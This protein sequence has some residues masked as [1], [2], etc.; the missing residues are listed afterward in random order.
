M[1]LRRTVTVIIFALIALL[2]YNSFKFYEVKSFKDMLTNEEALISINEIFQI[3]SS[4]FVISGV[5]IA[6]WQYVSTSRSEITKYKSERVQKAIELSGYYKDKILCNMSFLLKVYQ[7]TGI[8]EVIK[9]VKASKFHDFDEVELKE[10]YSEKQIEEIARI[11]HSQD[12]IKSVMETGELFD[13]TKGLTERRVSKSGDNTIVETVVNTPKLHHSFMD[14][15]VMSTL[16]NLEYFAMHFTHK[17]A[18]ESVVYQSLHSTYLEMVRILYY[19]IA[20]N[21]KMLKPKLYTNVVEL[22]NIWNEKAKKQIQ[23][24]ADK[25]RSTVLKGTLATMEK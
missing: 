2:L 8:L 3:V 14:N 9:G 6:V 17:V 10:N 12:F 16:N 13:F 7:D 11:I 20:I 23:T 19:N 24:Q 15:I 1:N 18:D 4:L 22:Y 5:F 21:N 25:A